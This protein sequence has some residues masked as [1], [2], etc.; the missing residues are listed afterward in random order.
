[1]NAIILAAG[2][3]TR[4]RPL[5]D[6]QPKCMVAV[7]GEPMIERQIRF[8]RDIGIEQII[9]VSGYKADRLE[10]LVDK[11]PGVIIVPNP[12]YDTCNNIYSM[13]V[14]QSYFGDSYVLEGD[15]YLQSNCLEAKKPRHSMYIAAYREHYEREWGL[16]V[17]DQHW[18]QAV[19]AG[20]GSGYI[21]S[22]VSYWTSQDAHLI[23]RRLNELIERGGYE[24]L[25]WDHVVL[26]VLPQLNIKVH[27]SNVLHELDTVEELKQ[28]E[29]YLA[30]KN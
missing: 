1:M 26:D 16:E 20:S 2:M 7:C 4:M 23:K 21:M 14:A 30:Q 12:I 5:T 24:E 22:G 8:L 17:D 13:Y 19:S 6:Q 3:G 25:F 11:Y 10:Y 28:L 15:V 9:L 29:V 18:L 27:A